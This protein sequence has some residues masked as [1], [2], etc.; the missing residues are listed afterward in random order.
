[1][2]NN[3]ETRHNNFSAFVLYI[4]ES[5]NNIIYFKDNQKNEGRKDRRKTDRQ[6]KEEEINKENTEM[7]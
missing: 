6:T 1:M 4:K 2:Y 7:T 3:E 5:L